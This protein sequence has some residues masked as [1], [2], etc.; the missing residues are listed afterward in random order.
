MLAYIDVLE[1]LVAE[2]WRGLN[3]RVSIVWKADLQSE[4]IER[5]RGPEQSRRKRCSEAYQCA[6]ITS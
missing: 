4:E 5:R 6:L 2:G 3:I 1:Y